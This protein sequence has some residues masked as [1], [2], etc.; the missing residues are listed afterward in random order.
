MKKKMQP[1][2]VSAIHL[3]TQSIIV[4]STMN[5]YDDYINGREDEEVEAGAQ[6]R[7]YDYY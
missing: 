5:V 7:Y 3:D 2:E 4:T 6:G 1:I